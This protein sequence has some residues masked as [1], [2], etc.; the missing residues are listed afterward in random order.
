MKPT[1]LVPALP[2]EGARAG[3]GPRWGLAA[4]AVV[5]GLVILALLGY[6][7]RRLPPDGGQSP[8]YDLV[9][10]GPSGGGPPT[11]ARQPRPLPPAQPAD[12][13]PPPDALPGP[14]APTP[15]STPDPTAATAPPPAADAAPP[16]VPTAAPAPEA[17]RPPMPSPA[18]AQ[19]AP[20]APATAAPPPVVPALPTDAATIPLPTPL[21]LPPT[22]EPPAVRLELP[23]EE[24]APAT[25][26]PIMPQP[27]PPLPPSEPQPRAARPAARPAPRPA[28]G[29]LSSPMDLSLGPAAP[30]PAARGSV[31]SRSLDL[32][33]PRERN[34]PASSDP[35]AQIR[36]ANA[37]ADWNRGLLQY[38]LRH[39]FYPEQAAANGE[40][41]AV[42]LQLTVN[43]SGRVESVEVL[44]RSGSQWLDM[45]AL[46]TW[47]NAQ[48]PPF[49]NEMRD[50]RITFPIPIQ[51][52]LIR[53]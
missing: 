44:S 27:P 45:A 1:P 37:S 9:F 32:S 13:T 25:P 40:E 39:R 29:T 36:A 20:P 16:P 50:D 19:T 51:Y 17:A 31:A 49:T 23:S 47:R 14:P 12:I 34:G 6:A 22:P 8:S 2:Q 21:E 43:R 4:S 30:R 10:E 46:A 5:H 52:Y 33:P 26:K 48:L 7:V 3:D 11:D 42:T 35:Y 18:P 38:W 28:L 41:G 53:H 24:T 15:L